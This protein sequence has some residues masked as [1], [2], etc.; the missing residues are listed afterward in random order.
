MP[1]GGVMTA[2]GTAFISVRGRLVSRL[3]IHERL[4]KMILE[5]KDAKDVL[6]ATVQEEDARLT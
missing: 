5:A 1:L 2:R 4:S 6:A 3:L